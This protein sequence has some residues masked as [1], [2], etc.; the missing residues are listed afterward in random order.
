MT[1][2]FQ[3]LKLPQVVDLPEAKY[4][5]VDEFKPKKTSPLPKEY[6]KHVEKS[7]QEMDKEVEYDLDEEVIVLM[8]LKVW[9]LEV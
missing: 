4:R 7:H 8:K 6:I 9:E 5:V 3:I 1:V 2:I